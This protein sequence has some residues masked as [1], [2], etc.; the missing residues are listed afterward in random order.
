[1]RAWWALA[2]ALLVTPALAPE[3]LAND[4]VSFSLDWKAE[5]EYGGFY[6]A[7]ATGIYARHGLDVTIV[8]GGPQ[9]NDMALLMAGRV[10]F[11]L[12]G[13]Q[14][15]QFVQEKLPFVAVAAIFQ[16]S[17]L[18]LIAH[19]G[20]G[21]DSFPAL[22]GKPIALGAGARAS[23]WRFLAAKFGYSESQVRPYTFNLAPFLADKNLVQEGYLGSEP[24][25]IEEQAHFK[26]VVLPIADAGFEGY[27]NIITTRTKLV[28]DNP[29]LVQRFVDASIEGWYSY[30]NS[31]PAPGDALICKANPDMPQALIDYGRGVMKSYGVVDSGDAKTMGIGAMTDARWKGFYQSMADVGV[32]PKGLDISP[33]YTLRFVDHRVGMAA[34]Q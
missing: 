26:P 16:K 1:M 33:A 23:W 24:Y 9:V 5:A 20:M 22:K 4:K 17:E 34:K 30:L 25:L 31:D 29:D 28:A 6:Q 11:N 3:A 8:E 7:L 10:Q 21:D 32:Y 27:A 12:G 2:L 15:V 13:G 19:P 14:A 18:V